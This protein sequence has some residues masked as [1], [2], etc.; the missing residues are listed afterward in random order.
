MSYAIYFDYTGAGRGPE[1]IAGPFDTEREAEEYAA[2]WEYDLTDSD[3]FIDEHHEVEDDFEDP[4]MSIS[5]EEFD[6]LF[7]GYN[8]GDSK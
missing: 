3:Y 5:D 8:T 1:V 4:L 6:E 7:P 2:E